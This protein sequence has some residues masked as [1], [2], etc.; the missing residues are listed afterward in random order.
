L[1]NGRY[2]LKDKDVGTSDVWESFSVVIDPISDTPTGYVACL[3]CDTLLKHNSS[4]G[5]S[6]LK[7][8]VSSKCDKQER[9]SN[10]RSKIKKKITKLCVQMCGQDCRPFNFVD[11]A[12]FKALAQEL[13]EIGAKTEV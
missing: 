4:S 5:V 2:A 3:K 6:T 11:G 12:G 8:H 10:G 7:R 9:R 13:I 1:S